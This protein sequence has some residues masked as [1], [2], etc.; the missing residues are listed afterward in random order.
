LDTALAAYLALLHIAGIEARSNFRPQLEIDTF[1]QGE[2]NRF[3][4]R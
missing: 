3:N 2:L 1:W 4:Q